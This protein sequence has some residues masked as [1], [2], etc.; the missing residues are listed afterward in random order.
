M[1]CY[2]LRFPR[3]RRIKMNQSFMDCLT[4]KELQEMGR[5]SISTTD[6]VTIGQVLKQEQCQDQETFTSL[7]PHKRVRFLMDEQPKPEKLLKS[8][9]FVHLSHKIRLSE[10]DKLTSWFDF[11][12]F[13]LIWSLE[14][15]IKY[16][17]RKLMII[18]CDKEDDHHSDY[19][20]I[21]YNQILNRLQV[22]G[23]YFMILDQG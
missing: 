20:S 11:R 17:D 19:L 15:A 13:E 5:L 21:N 3:I 6:K 9:Y 10:R 14:A 8:D 7:K 18:I 1:W 2:S 22:E 23:A 12:G 4:F 16:S